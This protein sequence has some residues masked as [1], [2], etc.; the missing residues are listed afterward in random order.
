MYQQFFKDTLISRYVKNL[1]RSTALPIYK[2]VEDGDFLVQGHLYVYKE[3]IIECFRSGKLIIS[4]KEKLYPS[5]NLY[6]SLKLFPNLP[7]ML[8]FNGVDKEKALTS[9]SNYIAEFKVIDY[10]NEDIYT[11]N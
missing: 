7:A 11:M 6:P 3:F 9:I 2:A 1:L 8:V 4:S 5:N 10:Y